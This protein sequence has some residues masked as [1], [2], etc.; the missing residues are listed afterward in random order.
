MRCNYDF[1]SVERERSFPD[2]HRSATIA[3]TRLNHSNL[4][5]FAK[6][7][8]DGQSDRHPRGDQDFTRRTDRAFPGAE[9]VPYRQSMSLFSFEWMGEFASYSA[10]DR[11]AIAAQAT[12]TPAL[13]LPR[14]TQVARTSADGSIA[15][16]FYTRRQARRS[17]RPGPFDTVAIIEPATA[18]S[19]KR[20]PYCSA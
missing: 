10:R 13:G 1:R 6:G 11:R 19:A 18:S 3:F 15:L 9:R 4:P 14:R 7:L 2:L 20:I 8:F 17:I 5:A 12:D 16:P